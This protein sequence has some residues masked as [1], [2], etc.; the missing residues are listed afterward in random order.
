MAGVTIPRMRLF[1]QLFARSS[2]CLVFLRELACA[3]AGAR[4]SCQSVGG[5][6]VC[7][8]TDP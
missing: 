8:I 3:I 4:S 7:F 5:G 6:G 2:R 1:V